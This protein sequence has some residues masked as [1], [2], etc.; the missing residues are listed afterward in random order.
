M[1]RGNKVKDC[2]CGKK[3]NRSRPERLHTLRGAISFVFDYLQEKKTEQKTVLVQAM[4]EYSGNTST[5]YY[6]GVIDTLVA[7]GFVID[8]NI[9]ESRS[10]VRISDY[11]S[12]V[13]D[14]MRDFLYEGMREGRNP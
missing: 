2:G 13:A 11:G 4:G 9:T 3:A 7:M 8:E 12:K 10:M 5:A 1:E 6:W 14:N